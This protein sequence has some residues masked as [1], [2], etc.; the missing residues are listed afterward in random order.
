MKNC[1]IFF[2]ITITTVLSAQVPKQLYIANDDHT[3]YMWAG[4]ENQY[5]EAFIKMLDYYIAQSD[6]T[7][8]LPSPYQSRFNCDGS[9]WLW[10]YEKNKT[11]GEFL[12]LIS[13]IKSGHISVPYNAVASCYGAAPAE[14][15][16]RGMYYAGELER[17]YKITIDKAVAMENQTLPLGLGSLWAGAGAKFSWKG[18]CN[19][20]SKL[21]DLKKRDKEIYW[22]KGIDDSKVLMKWYSIPNDN[23][24]LG[25]YSEARIPSR[26]VDQLD[27]LCHSAQHP[28]HI[29]GAF[30][31]GWDDLKTTTAIFTKT[32][33]E[34]TTA[35]RQ[36]IVSNQSDF[37]NAFEAAYGNEIPSESLAYGNEW[38][39]YSA[40]MAEVSANI[41]RSVEKL[42]AAETMAVLVSI[43]DKTFATHLSDIRKT[44]WMALGLYYE[45]NWTADG[46]VKRTDRAAWQRKIENQLSTYVDS[47]YALAQQRLG[48]YMKSSSKNMRFYVFNPLSWKRTD[49]ADF[50]YSETANANVVDITTNKEVPSQ[51]IIVHGKPHIRIL[52]TDIPSVGYKVFELRPGKP[53]STAPAANYFGNVFE[54]KFYKLTI[55]NQGVITSLI[56]KGNGNKECAANVNGKYMND[57]GSGNDNTGILTV[58]DV[59]PVSVTVVCKG[60]T[61][62]LHAT[63]ITLFNT[64]PRIDIENKIMQNFGDVQSWSF[65]HTIPNAEVW[66]EEI[67]AILKAKPVSEGGHYAS[68]N[69]RMDWLSLNHFADITNNG[70]GITL[71][72]ADCAFM[73]LGNSALSDLDTQT[74]QVSVLAGG[75]VDGESLGILK[76]DRDSLFTQRFA[77]G[78]H[79]TSFDAAASMRFSM[80]HQNPLV[81][82]VVTGT[83]T[84]Y[85]EKYYSFLSIDD[86]NVL[87][88]SLKPAE[89]GIEKGIIARVWNFGS[90]ISSGKISFKDDIA[91]AK[92]TT[93]VETDKGNA[94]IEKGDLIEPI[95]HHQ[96]KTFRIN[97]KE[98]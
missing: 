3:D 74:A 35:K 71:S 56:D 30:G 24:Q 18:V 69:A 81:T 83:Q 21:T 13:K 33:M 63:R 72:N 4:N 45:H 64:I 73:K 67:G 61:P 9:F 92:Q 93:H 95:G 79:Q 68:Q 98:E 53:K 2:F 5:R 38:D 87:V 20:A 6:S 27:T 44:A 94:A 12:K 76:Q 55:T 39:V 40:S 23:Q 96:M 49:V 17:K 26:A 84:I 85:H 80:E 52:A 62:L 75:Q 22:Y 54:N 7:A 34:K 37:F 88:W 65:S 11:S 91:S 57:L 82:G 15:I 89:D 8:S 47:L 42:R 48:N 59:G 97:L 25:G 41:K 1:F 43:T 32:A 51:S 78:T 10:E 14:G 60:K 86:T 77:L 19:C 16:L 50:P 28:Y 58:E 29:A 31:F 90:T 46:P 36:V 66:H 70:Y